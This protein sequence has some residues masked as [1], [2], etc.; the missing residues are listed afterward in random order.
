MSSKSGIRFFKTIGFKITLWYSVSVLVIL[1]I[2]GS[3]LYFRLKHKLIKEVDRALMDDSVDILQEIS[4]DKYIQSDLKVAIEKEASNKKFHKISA[5]LL[6]VEKNTFITSTNFFSPDSQ[7]YEESITKAKAKAKERVEDTFETIRVEGMEF[8]F[9]LLTKPIYHADSLKYILQMSFYLKS[10]CKSVEN[11]EENFIMLIPA[12]IIFS[13]AGGW[14]IAR[15]SLAPIENIN[16]TTRKITATNLSMRL[17]PTHAGDEL[18]ELTKTI[19]LMLNRIEESFSRIIQFTS[20]AS[21]ELRTPITSLKTGTEVILSKERTA[22]EYRELHENN[23]RELKKITRMISDLLILLRSDSGTKNLHPKSLNLGNVLKE[24]QNTFRL[25]SE[26][27][28][29]N[30]STNGIPD[31]QINGDEILLRRVF[32]NL[33]DNAIKYTSPGGRVY[34]SLRDKGDKVMVRIEDTGIGI[35]EDHL[36]RIFNRFFRVDP[37]RSRETGGTGLGLNICKNIVELHKGK[38]EVKSKLGAGST[39][40]VILPKDHTNS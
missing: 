34:V 6:D 26:T 30:L 9:R 37:S 40:E 4:G 17:S 13:I 39:F 12:L 10:M 2:A 32:S 22:E 5:R 35:S 24:L 38:I 1:L 21:H 27:K 11:I 8:P 18:D 25:I 14:L 33:L 28:K 20:D 23:L 7:I 31:I 15:K 16:E 3:F 29:V 19:N 36:G